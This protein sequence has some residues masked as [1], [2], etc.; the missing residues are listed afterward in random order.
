MCI[1]LPLR[2]G[3]PS[4]EVVVLQT[5]TV[6]PPPPHLGSNVIITLKLVLLT[7]TFLPFFWI[8]LLKPSSYRLPIR[9]HSSSKSSLICTNSWPP[10][11]VQR[12]A[13]LD[14]ACTRHS[15]D[16]AAHLYNLRHMPGSAAV[17]ATVLPPFSAL[18]L[19][20]RSLSAPEGFDRHRYPFS[21]VLPPRPPRVLFQILELSSPWLLTT[22]VGWVDWIFLGVYCNAGFCWGNIW[23]KF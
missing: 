14:V 19:K 5:W 3:C 18:G 16:S 12:S 7:H 6:P 4:Y 23:V 9:S 22:P 21:S 15:T 1:W 11:P 2:E 8:F 20:T 17:T 13:H 10:L